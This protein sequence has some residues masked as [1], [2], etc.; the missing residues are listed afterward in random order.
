MQPDPDQLVAVYARFAKAISGI[1]DPTVQDLHRV[2]AQVPEFVAQA[3]L[4]ERQPT[5]AQ[6][7]AGLQQ[8]LLD[9]PGLLGAVDVQ[10]RWAV[11]R[12]FHDAVMR[13]CPEFLVLDAQRLQTLL[14]RGRIDTESEFCLVRHRID[15]LEGEAELPEELGKLHVLAG[16]YDAGA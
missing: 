14:E 15:V 4:L 16:T 11:S 12:A 6:I 8:G 5:N 2:V 10:W 9:M 1:P 3:R 7:A 13:E